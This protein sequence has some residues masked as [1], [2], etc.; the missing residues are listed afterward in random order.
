LDRNARPNIIPSK[1]KLIILGSFLILINSFNES[2][3]NNNKN[4]SVL[5]INDEKLTAGIEININPQNKELVVVRPI[6]LHKS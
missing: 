6:F 1:I 2:T 3:Q 4:I 5:K